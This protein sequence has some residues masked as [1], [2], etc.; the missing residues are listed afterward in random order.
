[1]L[2][3]QRNSTPYSSNHLD[4]CPLN[5]PGHKLQHTHS[6]SKLE[7]RALGMLGQCLAACSNLRQRSMVQ[8]LSCAYN[9]Q[10]LWIAVAGTR[11]CCCQA[12]NRLQ[13][14]RSDLKAAWHLHECTVQVALA[15]KHC[16]RRYA[17]RLIVAPT[18]HCGWARDYQCAQCIS[19]QCISVHC[20][21]QLSLP[22]GKRPAF[23]MLCSVDDT[24]NL[25]CQ[26]RNADRWRHKVILLHILHA[27]L[28]YRAHCCN[29]PSHTR[30]P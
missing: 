27:C 10:R 3:N 11:G 23:G 29:K 5:R 22:S 18:S 21:T 13:Q 19:A 6:I 9:V 26:Q 25:V 20:S 17:C 1:M 14:H 16:C 15:A 30:F 2:F 8:H 4:N 28:A 12:H 24:T 7:A